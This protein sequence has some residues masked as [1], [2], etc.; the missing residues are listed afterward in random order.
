M[1]AYIKEYVITLKIFAKNLKGRKAMINKNWAY[2][3]GILSLSTAMVAADQASNGMQ[4]QQ[5]PRPMGVTTQPQG[6][7]TPPVA[8]T[9]NNGA[10]F[11]IEADFIYWDVYQEGLTV[12]STGEATSVVSGQKIGNGNVVSL[13]RS[14]EPGFKIGFGF[15]MEHDGWDVFVD[16]TWLN[17]TQANVSYPVTSNLRHYLAA[18]NSKNI[19]VPTVTQFNANSQL[20]FN[21]IDLE[22][23]RSFFLSRYLTLR[24]HIGL[25]TAWI[26]QDFNREYYLSTALASSSKLRSDQEQQFW[27]IGIRTGLSPVFHLS[28]NWGIYGDLA[29]S[30]LYGYNQD[31]IND[32][33]VNPSGTVFS[34]VVNEYSSYHSLTPVI[35]F[36]LGLEYMTWFCNDSYMFN[37]KAGWEEQIWFNTNQFIEADYG[38]LMLQGFTFNVGFHF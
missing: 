22:L 35:E 14:W 3:L 30:A 12:A 25:K 2:A 23:G 37:V 21:A 4:Q 5:A 16:W 29:L 8:P 11:F 1:I 31:Q 6:V 15:E 9:V 20:H 28:K 33:L 17:P 24:P 7:I 38:N 18:Y 36:G 32:Y 27:G 19:S 26:N 13:G 10:D 34:E